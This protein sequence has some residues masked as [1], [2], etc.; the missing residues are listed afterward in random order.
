MQMNPTL[1]VVVDAAKGM[2]LDIAYKAQKAF[3]DAICSQRYLDASD[4]NDYHVLRLMFSMVGIEDL[5]IQ[6]G[7]Q[8]KFKKIVSTSKE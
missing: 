5:E 8:E 2:V 7:M 1:Q 6:P 4:E 3:I